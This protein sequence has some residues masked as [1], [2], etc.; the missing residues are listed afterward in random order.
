MKTERKNGAQSIKYELCRGEP[1]R[2]RCKYIVIYLIYSYSFMASS[3]DEDGEE[4]WR[5]IQKKINV[6]GGSPL[7]INVNL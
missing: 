2:Y 5:A 1:T 7:D 4:E 6:V 3:S